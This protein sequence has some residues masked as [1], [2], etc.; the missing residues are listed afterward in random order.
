MRPK[1]AF[2]LWPWRAARGKP[3]SAATF[4]ERRAALGFCLHCWLTLLLLAVAGLGQLRL[5]VAGPCALVHRR[6]GT[7]HAAVRQPLFPARYQRG[8]SAQDRQGHA[9]D[10][11][12]VR[13]GYLLAAGA[14]LLLALPAA[15]RLGG[16]LKALTRFLLNALRSVPELVWAALMVLAAGLGPFAGTLALALHTAGVLGR[17]FAESLENAPPEPARALVESG[18]APSACLRLRH[19]ARNHAAAHLL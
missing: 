3:M 17:L 2:S 4:A 11:G 8:I 12:H 7:R 15:G 5:S 10:T 1:R 18:A 14:A 6:V 19:A 16:A 9:G 13:P